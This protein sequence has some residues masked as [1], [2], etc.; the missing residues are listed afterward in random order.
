MG[1]EYIQFYTNPTHF[2]RL[3][4]AKYP[5]P[6]RF[7]ILK[8]Q[9]KV[10]S[11]YFPTVENPTKGIF[12]YLAN[13]TLCDFINEVLIKS[14]WK[15]N[16]LMLK[17]LT[18]W[19]PISL[20]QE[21]IFSNTSFQFS[22]KTKYV[23][24][25]MF[26]I[27]INSSKYPVHWKLE[28]SQENSPETN[29]W[30]TLFEMNNQPCNQKGTNT[31]YFRVQNTDIFSSFRFTMIGKNS[32]KTKEL[33][34]EAFDLFGILIDPND[35]INSLINQ[36]GRTKPIIS[37]S[38]SYHFPLSRDGHY[39]LFNI[40]SSYSVMLALN[41]FSII[42]SPTLD[43][44]SVFNVMK[45]DDSFWVS[46]DQENMFFSFM[47]SND[48]VFKLD[49]YRIRS[50]ENYFPKSWKLEGITTKPSYESIDIQENNLCICEKYND[51][52]FKVPENQYFRGFKVTQIGKNAHGTH[53]FS[54][55]AIEWFGDLKSI[56]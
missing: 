24:V 33:Y 36:I 22:F 17:F 7:L 20:I 44:T 46:E 16:Y 42:R 15:N 28:A 50:A 6:M 25:E 23:L 41:T 55:S 21:S 4:K 14:M 26:F 54:I 32:I 11:L 10:E 8:S 34:L 18:S 48:L 35:Q 43:N 40:L 5:L 47:F 51:Q 3:L 13:L 39:G 45:W 53:H 1:N 9:K 19:S 27:E 30:Q 29:K 38:I 52:L 2:D 49:G 37:H 56:A 31:Y 12:Q